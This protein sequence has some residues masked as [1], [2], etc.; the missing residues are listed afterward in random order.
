M[1]PLEASMIVADK[2]YIFN[3]T[4]SGNVISPPSDTFAIGS[5]G[6]FALCKFLYVYVCSSV[7]FS[8][9]IDELHTDKLVL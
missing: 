8:L 1:Q 6:H 5:G 2:D 3:I 7:Y 4:G 9:R